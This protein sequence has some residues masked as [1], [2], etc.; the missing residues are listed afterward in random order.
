MSKANP[1]FLEILVPAIR[2]VGKAEMKILLSGLKEHNSPEFYENVLKSI[3]SNF[4][5]LKDIAT[6]TKTRFDDGI[7]GLVLEAVEES[8]AA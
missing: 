3:Q 4:I 2:S 8:F 6:K 1:L 5:L 7:I